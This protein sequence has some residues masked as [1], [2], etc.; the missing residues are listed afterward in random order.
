M[1]FW[2]IN[3][4]ITDGATAYAGGLSPGA[5]GFAIGASDDGTF[6][7]ITGRLNLVGVWK[8]A[9]TAGERACFQNGGAGHLWRNCAVSISVA[10]F[11]CHAGLATSAIRGWETSSAV[12]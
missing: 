10:I 7:F 4:N 9:F 6:A 5:S 1:V 2:W 12:L 8:K 11:A 3:N